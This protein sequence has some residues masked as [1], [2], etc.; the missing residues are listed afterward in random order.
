MI[1][2]EA[3]SE[4][5]FRT[6]Q[7]RTRGGGGGTRRTQLLSTRTGTVSF[8]GWPTRKRL[9]AKI[10]GSVLKLPMAPVNPGS[11]PL[12]GNGRE[13]KSAGSDSSNVKGDKLLVLGMKR[14]AA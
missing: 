5:A 10:G 14:L 4:F 1:G 12:S 8:T 2:G 13:I 9:V 7:S 3:P 11:F 6:C